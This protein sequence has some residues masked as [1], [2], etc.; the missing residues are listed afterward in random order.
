MKKINFIIAIALIF[1]F[2]SDVFAGE[3]KGKNEA[4][5]TICPVMGGKIN[6]NLYVDYNGQRIYVC[7]PGCIDTVK[8][9]P[10]KYIKKINENGETP[11]KIQII[12][13]VM[14]GKINKK[15]FVDH[16]GK[17]IYVCCP[18]CI[19]TIKNNPEKYIKEMEEKGVVFEEAPKM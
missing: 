9:D 8:K 16:G 6:K 3:Q 15:L 13:P 10:E 11:A 18:A 2:T 4:I 17:R 12:C 14:G 19:D 7:C 5:Q 1:L